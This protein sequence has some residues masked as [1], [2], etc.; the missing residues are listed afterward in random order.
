MHVCQVVLRSIPSRAV[1]ILHMVLHTFCAGSKHCARVQRYNTLWKI[2]RVLESRTPLVPCFSAARVDALVL[3]LHVAGSDLFG[4]CLVFSGSVS[5][6]SPWSFMRR[7]WSV[8]GCTLRLGVDLVGCK[9]CF[10]HNWEG[11]AARAAHWN[12]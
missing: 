1:V 5:P 8:E 9:P 6:L 12:R 3:L 2:P 10:R 11:T 7:R 4:M